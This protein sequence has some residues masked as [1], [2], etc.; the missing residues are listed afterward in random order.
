MYII[1]EFPIHVQMLYDM[2][3]YVYICLYTEMHTQRQAGMPFIPVMHIYRYIIKTHL[4]LILSKS[5]MF[6]AFCTL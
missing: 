3:M 5:L 6:Y 4:I 1:W 2:H